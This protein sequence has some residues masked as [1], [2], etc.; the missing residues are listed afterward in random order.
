MPGYEFPKYVIDFGMCLY[1]C[2]PVFVFLSSV[3]AMYIDVGLALYKG[4]SIAKN[5]LLDAQSLKGTLAASTYIKEVE[6][7]F[8]NKM[9]TEA[10]VCE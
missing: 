3:S 4:F 7:Q 10:M 2:F 9:A 6:A 8:G 5:V 1:T